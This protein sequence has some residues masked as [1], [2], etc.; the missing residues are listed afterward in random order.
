[1]GET[2]KLRITLCPKRILEGGIVGTTDMGPCLSEC[3]ACTYVDS[4]YVCAE[5]KTP[6]IPKIHAPDTEWHGWGDLQ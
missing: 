5:Y 3:A 1:M 6:I 2:T 4:G